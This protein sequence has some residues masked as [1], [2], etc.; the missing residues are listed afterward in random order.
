MTKTVTK[1]EIASKIATDLGYMQYKVKTVLDSLLEEIKRQYKQ[2]NR[3]ELRHFGVFYPHRRKSRT[4]VNPKTGKTNKSSGSVVLK[5]K[6]SKQ[7]N[8]T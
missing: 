1:K 2:G 6:S 7:L 3:I 5:F 8:L 4:Y